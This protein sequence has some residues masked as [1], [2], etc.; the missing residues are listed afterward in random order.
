MEKMV[1]HTSAGG[2]AA[3]GDDDLRE[4]RVVDLLESSCLVS[5]K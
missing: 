2:H 3:G 4:M 5:K 1:E